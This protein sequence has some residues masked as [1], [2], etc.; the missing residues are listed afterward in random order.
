MQST[1][2]YYCTALRG[3]LVNRNSTIQYRLRI[4]NIKSALLVL[5][6]LT[7][8]IFID[9]NIKSRFR[10]FSFSYKLV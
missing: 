1:V 10:Y 4:L 3:K 8:S 6:L 2:S 9:T 5:F 7:N